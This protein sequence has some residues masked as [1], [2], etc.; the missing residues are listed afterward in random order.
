MYAV[1]R[2]RGRAGRTS[3]VPAR[4][5]VA[6][7]SNAIVELRTHPTATICTGTAAPGMDHPEDSAGTRDHLSCPL[8]AI[9]PSFLPPGYRRRVAAPIVHKKKPG[10]ILSNESL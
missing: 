10:K 7:I 8:A 9:V 1:R 6:K 3:T 2:L 4:Q 5:K